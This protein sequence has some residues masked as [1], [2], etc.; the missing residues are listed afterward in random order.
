MRLLIDMNLSRDWVRHL[1]AADFVA[2]HWADVGPADALDPDI[3]AFARNNDL[4]VVTQD[5]DFGEILAL[6]R[7]TG[8]SVVQLRGGDT[9]PHIGAP[10]VIAALRRF[11]RQINS[12]ALVTINLSRLRVRLLPI[13]GQEP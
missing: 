4:I 13:L 6:N 2:M 3:M 12:G 11:E 7:E 10:N 9:M 8:P 5:L 1:S